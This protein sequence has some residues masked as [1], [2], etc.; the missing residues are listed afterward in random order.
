M[1]LNEA[2]KLL[3]SDA[4]GLFRAGIK[5]RNVWVYF[6]PDVDGVIA[7]LLVYEYLARVYKIRAK[8]HMNENRAHGC[9][10]E[11]G[12][13]D[14][15][16][17]NVDSGTTLTDLEKF[18]EGNCLLLSLD[19]HKLPEYTGPY[20][21]IKD[22]A[23]VYNSDYSYLE[24]RYGYLSGAG[25]VALFFKEMDVRFETELTEAYVG[26]T[27]LSDARP[28]ENEYA[29]QTLEY[30]YSIRARSIPFVKVNME[31][32]INTRYDSTAT[33]LDRNF[34]DFKLSPYINAALRFSKTQ[35]L[36]NSLLLGLECVD[37]RPQQKELIEATQEVMQTVEYNTFV[38]AVVKR[39]PGNVFL[40]ELEPNFIGLIANRLLNKTGKSVLILYQVGK[41]LKR[42]SVRGRY[43]TIDYLAEFR[44]LGFQAAGHT[45]AFGVLGIEQGVNMMELD[46][47]IRVAEL[48]KEDTNEV[49]EISNLFQAV[50]RIRTIAYENQF[51]RPLYKKYL[52]YTGISAVLVDERKNYLIYLVDGL[53]VRGFDNELAFEDGRILPVYNNKSVELVIE[54]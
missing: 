18:V 1:L 46:E 40:T 24:E 45:G 4:E 53:E 28:I 12:M 14:G 10:Y 8:V 36:L 16:V 44:K 47:A 7:G 21:G 27:L 48:Q 41:E 52:K 6:D 26:I 37:Y 49:I 51:V 42:G 17:I 13:Q 39:D 30:T 3:Q 15:F 9:F 35:E 22:K 25:V 50:N 34:I 43:H 32:I 33:L 23:I 54:N 19:H 20:L 2:H 11:K 5:R 38:L 31:H 29:R